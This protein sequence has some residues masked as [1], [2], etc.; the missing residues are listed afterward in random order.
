[1]A[2]SSL[3]DFKYRPSHKITSSLILSDPDITPYC[4]DLDQRKAVF[5]T[6]PE[7]ARTLDATFFY[8][9]QFQRAT[10]LIVISF[11]ELNELVQ[12]G[13]RS[14]QHSVEIY[15]TGR[16][17]STLLAR[18]LAS[19]EACQ[20]VCEPDMPTT[21]LQ[22]DSPAI[23]KGALAR[24]TVDLL[25]NLIRNAD[26][27]Y[28][29]LKYRPICMAQAEC[30]H[31][32]DEQATPVF[33]YRNAPDFVAS[34]MSALRYRGSPLYFTD[35]LHRGFVTRPI[36][37]ALFRLNRKSATRVLPFVEDYSSKELVKLGPVGLLT[38]A[39]ISMIRKYLDLTAAGKRFV[40]VQYDD[41]VSDPENIV[42][43]LL[44]K[45]RL[46]GSGLDSALA[47]LARDSQRGS[48][49]DRRRVRK[50]RL[51]AQGR[52]MIDSLLEREDAMDAYPR[53]PGDIVDD[54]LPRPMDVTRAPLARP[55]EEFSRQTSGA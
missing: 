29:I 27:R 42:R 19:S 38:M 20:A 46:P 10:H 25:G 24:T 6:T 4:Y 18:M 47:E 48:M 15:S 11:E 5:V 43:Q 41:L 50:Y 40:A 3:K 22:S 52:R 54:A 21:A 7:T 53:L 49:V 23:R 16:C 39:W 26:K 8:Q 36:L 28:L 33:I 32:A 51:D 45:C 17:G 31:C 9:A 55:H 30:L 35:L 12:R 37:S 44:S 2:F 1:M 34:A 13:L 14:P